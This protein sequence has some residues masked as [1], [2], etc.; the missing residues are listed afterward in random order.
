MYLDNNVKTLKLKAIDELSINRH[1]QRL[2]RIDDFP[3]ILQ[4]FVEHLKNNHPIQKG[5][6]TKRKIRKH[7]NI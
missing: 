4:D 5:G 6:R 1:G 3:H 7:E 2:L